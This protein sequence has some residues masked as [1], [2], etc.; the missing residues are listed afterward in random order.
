MY[1]FSDVSPND[2]VLK[3]LRMNVAQPLMEIVYLQRF[4][5]FKS[6]K[7]GVYILYRLME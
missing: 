7:I 4:E 3:L 5:G 2:N 1:L 6:G